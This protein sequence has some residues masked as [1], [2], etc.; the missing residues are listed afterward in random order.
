MSQYVFP[1]EFLFWTKNPEHGKH[2]RHLVEQ[3]ESTLH[4]TKDQHAGKWVCSV[5]TEYFS[6]SAV[7]EKYLDLIS[8]AI[9]PALDEM[10]SSVANLRLPFQSRVTKI[11]YN[12]YEP[13]ASAGQEAHMHADSNFS[14]IYFL[15]LQEPNT[16]MF[17]SP[18]AASNPI[19]ACTKHSLFV[20][21]G[22]I[23]LFPSTLTHYVLPSVAPR[24]TVA[25]NVRCN[26]EN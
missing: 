18:T 5:N 9:Y 15:S 25:F 23:L 14:G 7:S 20:E 24:T 21:E 22:D 26:Y 19:T 10:F 4:Q 2:K 16:T 8:Q 12:H 13:S 6:K 17:Y 3:V 1:M 11:W